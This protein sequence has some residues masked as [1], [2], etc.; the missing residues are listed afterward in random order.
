MTLSTSNAGSGTVT[1]DTVTNSGTLAATTANKRVGNILRKA[2]AGF[3]KD[4]PDGGGADL[5]AE[6][7]ELTVHGESAWGAVAGF[8]RLRFPRP[9]AEPAVRLSPQ[10]ALHGLCRGFVQAAW[11]QGLGIWFPR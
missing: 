7:G 8:P 11:V 5:V 9:L 10:R 3:A 4:L 2:D 1:A 6:S